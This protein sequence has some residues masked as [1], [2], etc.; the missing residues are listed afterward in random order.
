MHVCVYIVSYLACAMAPEGEAGK[1]C[2]GRSFRKKALP[3]PC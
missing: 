1:K 2:L 3:M